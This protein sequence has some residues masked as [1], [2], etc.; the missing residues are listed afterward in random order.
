LAA[1]E[2]SQDLA[3]PDQLAGAE[4]ELLQADHVIRRR[5]RLDAAGFR[6]R[7]VDNVALGDDVEHVG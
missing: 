5:F 6:Q 7:H 3:K 2:S 1:S 4:D